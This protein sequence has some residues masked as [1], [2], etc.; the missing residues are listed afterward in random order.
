M[1]TACVDAP[2]NQYDGENHGRGADDG[3]A[4]KNWLGRRFKRISRPVVFFEQVLCAL[5]VDVH[6]EVLFDFLLHVRH[7]LNQREFID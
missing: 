6:V 1:V 3:G 2:V 7:L 5:E 4:D